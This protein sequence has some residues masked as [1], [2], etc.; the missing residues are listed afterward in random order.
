LPPVAKKAIA[1]AAPIAANICWVTRARCVSYSGHR[2][3]LSTSRPWST[4]NVDYPKCLPQLP[5]LH[6][7]LQS[8]LSTL[9]LTQLR[10]QQ[11]RRRH[12]LLRHPHPHRPTTQLRLR[13]TPRPLHV[14]RALTALPAVL[15]QPVA[16]AST[17]WTTTLPPANPVLQVFSPPLVPL[18]APSVQSA[19]IM[20]HLAQS[21]ART[22][23]RA[24]TAN[25]TS[26]TQ[27]TASTAHLASIRTR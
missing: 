3:S 12:T 18:S 27:P 23:P 16:L 6:I 25:G 22:V 26:R 8:R 2:P 7:L 13:R 11:P 14:F 20:T 10:H 4:S 15:A 1:L 24:H 9:L 19:A 21:S 5:L 17:L